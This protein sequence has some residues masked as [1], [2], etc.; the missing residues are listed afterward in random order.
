M[1]KIE[2]LIAAVFTP[3]HE[4]GSLNLEM[5][6]LLVE[7][8]IADGAT[9]IFACGSNGEGPNMTSTER[10]KVAEAFVKA[11]KGR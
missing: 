9:G 6:P 1:K 8:L 5:I 3:F 7:K 2:G 10:M 11:A 4:D